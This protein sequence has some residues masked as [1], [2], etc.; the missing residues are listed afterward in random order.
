MASSNFV[1][2]VKI[3]CRSGA[4]GAGSAHFHRDKLNAKGGPDGGDGGRGG[5][6]ILKGNAHLWTLLHLKY[7]KHVIASSGNNGALSLQTGA[8]GKDEILEVPLGTIARNA[9]TGELMFEILADGEERILTPGGRGGL[10]NWHFKSPTNQ[11]PRNAQPGE[12][13]LEEW[14]VREEITCSAANLFSEAATC[15]G[16]NQLL[17]NRL[18]AVG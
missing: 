16:V 7:R 2:Y 3:C 12:S 10:G 6:I 11:S 5:N 15:I 18:R 1:D 8:S 14:K 17:E 4:G 13:G 9:E